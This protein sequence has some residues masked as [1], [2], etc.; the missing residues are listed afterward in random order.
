V[1]QRV[2]TPTGKVEGDMGRPAS[3]TR[4]SWRMCPKVN[5]RRNSP[6]V[7]GHHLVAEQFGR[8]G[9]PSS[10]IICLVGN[11]LL[12]VFWI[13][14]VSPETPNVII[15]GGAIYEV[16]GASSRSLQGLQDMWASGANRKSYSSMIS[17][18]HCPRKSQAR[19]SYW[20]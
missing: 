2:N 6:G 5:Q 14:R 10:V 12:T 13:T 17:G 1:T 19:L 15:P 8:R 18:R 11:R 16:Y 4:S 20:Y 9:G 3:V 7:E